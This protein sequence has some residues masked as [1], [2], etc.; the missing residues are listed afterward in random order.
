MSNSFSKPC[1][2]VIGLGY[3]GLPLAIEFS[4]FFRVIGFDINSKKIISLK[5]GIDENLEIKNIDF[6]K[7]NILFTN[8]P[9]ALHEASFFIICVPTPIL[10][11]FKP[12]L[13][14]IINATK[15]VGGF[16][17]KGDLV[18]YESTVFPGCTED[19]CNPILE[20]ISKLKI[21][22]DYILGYSPERINPG[23]KKRKLTKIAKV[24]S[25]SSKVGLIK[26]YKIYSKVIKAKIYK[27][28]SI[29]VAEAS[30]IL[31]NVQRSL[32]ISLINEVS[33]IFKKMNINTK[34][35][36]EA[37]RTKWNFMDYRPGLV[38]GHCI[39]VD[40][41][42]LSYKAKEL[43]VSSKLIL[44]GQ[45]INES[46][47]KLISDKI[48]KILSYKK[49]IHHKILILGVTF[50]ENCPDLRDSKVI[51]IID[52]LSNKKNQIFIF[53]PWTKKE[54]LKKTLNKKIIFLDQLNINSKFDVII[55]AVRHKIFKKIGI[56]KIKNLL[57]KGGYIYDVKNFFHQKYSNETL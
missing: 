10:P 31:E 27:A 38:G 25:A 22:K 20:R 4:K 37:A 46:I 28:T 35:V 1:I 52:N 41:Y 16:L 48:L 9:N 2:A 14:Y 44:S 17:K 24:I 5:K 47:P 3:V 54:S 36:I 23:D 55:I 39:A 34:E 43:G 57:K 33:V 29:K 51:N 56:K 49:R 6:K 40:P 30:K 11:N 26:I 21:N 42:Y 53:D 45:E 19:I 12:D 18:I 32:N 7:K 15:L 13:S 50:K 8:N